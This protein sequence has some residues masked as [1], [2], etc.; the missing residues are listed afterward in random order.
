MRVPIIK[1]YA[2]MLLLAT[3]CWAAPTE[4]TLFTFTGNAT[5]IYP[6]GGV[7]LDKEGH[8]YGTALLGGAT[9]NGAVFE[10]V[11]THGVWTENVIYSF[12]GGN[13]GSLPATALTFD[14]QGNLFGTTSGGGTQAAGTVFE[15]KWS[16]G[17]WTETVIHNFVQTDGEAPFG[18]LIFDGKGNL[19]GT[20]Q[21]GGGRG[22]CGNGGC[23]TVFRLSPQSGG[24]WKQTVLHRFTGAKDGA[25]PEAGVIFDQS[26]NLYGATFAGGIY[27]GVVFELSPR[28]KGPWKETILH[29]FSAKGKDGAYST[30]RLAFDKTGNLY[31]TTQVAGVGGAGIV[32]KLTHSKNKWT[33]SVPYSFTGGGDG[34]NPL[35]GVTVSPAGDLY[36]TTN[37][38]GL[39]VGVVYE[40]KHS[41][42][43]WVENVLFSFDARSD[44]AYPIAGVTL[45]KAGN[46]FGTTDGGGETQSLG[47]VFEIL[48]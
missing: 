4:K 30:S 27:A 29:A 14:G 28:S 3:A 24:T 45:D 8:V 16:K 25:S 10:L 15:L 41:K 1:I 47:S 9:G 43:G 20:T 13:D 36:G 42:S 6:Y 31:G 33:E 2:V 44:G 46:I 17:T 38:G 48:P 11:K 40:L 26:G 12:A 7:T 39:G 37:G 22:T 35:S 32:F 34:A 19:Y 21:E 5:G 23:G 18:D